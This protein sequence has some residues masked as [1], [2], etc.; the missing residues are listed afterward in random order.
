MM[1]GAAAA[2]ETALALFRR[3]RQRAI[4]ATGWVGAKLRDVPDHVFV[5]ETIPHTWLFPRVR[6]V[7]QHGGIGS[8]A[9]ALRA[10]VP[11]ICIAFSVEQEF[12]GHAVCRLGVSPPPI[13]VRRLDL[14]R[15]EAV[16]SAVLVDSGMAARARTVGEKVRAERG[17]EN[18]VQ[19]IDRYLKR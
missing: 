18:A 2:L 11:T 10:G 14:P 15:L 8:T 12:W 16:L 4:I 5:V 13:P 6:C 3:T 1:G 19:V 17:V 7:I 9:A